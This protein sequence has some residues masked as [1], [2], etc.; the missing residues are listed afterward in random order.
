[1]HTVLLQAGLEWN[2]A[3]L[4]MFLNMCQNQTAVSHS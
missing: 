1:M 2:D 3:N 4:Q